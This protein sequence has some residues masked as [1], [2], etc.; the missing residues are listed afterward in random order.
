PQNVLAP[1]DVRSLAVLAD[2]EVVKSEMRVLSPARLFGF[3]RLLN[4]FV[5]PFPLVRQLCLRHYTVCRSLRALAPQLKSASIVIP[6]RN[7]RGNIEPAIR[8]IPQFAP[9]QEII[10]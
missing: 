10:F 7:E 8:R 3:G 2:F 1:A 4:R 5:A 9:E 6:A